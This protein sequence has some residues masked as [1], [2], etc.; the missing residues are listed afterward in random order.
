ME[1]NFEAIIREEEKPLRK[2]SMFSC[3]IEDIEPKL[4]GEAL[5]RL[6]EVSTGATH[7]T[8][9]QIRAILARAVGDQSKLRGL[10]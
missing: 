6:E 10:A 9:E 1:V 2:L 7:V 5:N 4:V 3:T 8:R